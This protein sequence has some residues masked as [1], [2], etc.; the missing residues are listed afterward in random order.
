MLVQFR[1]LLGPNFFNPK[2]TRLTHLLSFASL[3]LELGQ[4]FSIPFTFI[5]LSFGVSLV[6][7]DIL[8]FIIFFIWCQCVWHWTQKEQ[9]MTVWKKLKGQNYLPLICGCISWRMWGNSMLNLATFYHAAIMPMFFHTTKRMAMFSTAMHGNVY[10][11]FAGQCLSQ[12]SHW[13][14]FCKQTRRWRWSGELGCDIF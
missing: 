14:P 4:P 2:L 1:S 3:S 7:F 13:G 11:S 6:F 12:V 9:G 5:V 10:Y 8:L